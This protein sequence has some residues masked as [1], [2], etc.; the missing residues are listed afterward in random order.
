VGLVAIQFEK[1]RLVKGLRVGEVFPG[2]KGKHG[3]QVFK[4]SVYEEYRRKSE[5]AP[6]FPSEKRAKSLIFP[7]LG[8]ALF[9]LGVIMEEGAD[10]CRYFRF[11]LFAADPIQDGNQGEDCYQDDQGD[12]GGGIYRDL[13]CF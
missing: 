1:I 5:T 10:G 13:H 8:P 6:H 9:S 12:L 4:F 11:R 7:G 3:G 2:D